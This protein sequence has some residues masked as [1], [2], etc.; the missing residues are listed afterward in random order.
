[1]LRLCLAIALVAAC[2]GATPSVDGPARETHALS[3][4]D[5][6]I[7]LPLP[8]SAKTP[9][10]MGVGDGMVDRAWFEALVIDRSDIAPKNGLSFQFSDFQVVAIRFE[11]CDPEQ[12]D[13]C[14]AGVAA[15]FRVVWQ[16]MFTDAG[17]HVL[18][19]DIAAHGFYPV[20]TGDI[21]TVIAELRT[22]AAIQGLEPTAP[23]AVSPAASG[24]NAEYLARLKAL[25]AK[26]A[27]S[28]NLVRLTVIGQEAD[29]GAFA[30]IFRGLD[31]DGT[32]FQQLLIPTI[33]SYQ[34]TT[35]V[36]AGDTIYT[37]SKAADFPS[38]FLLALNGVLFDTATPDEQERALESVVAVQ[39]PKLHDTVDTQCIG[40]HLANHLTLQRASKLSVDPTTVTG[41]FKSTF[42]TAASGIGTDPRIVR[43]FGWASSTPIVSQR[44]ANETALV[45]ANIAAR[46]PVT[47]L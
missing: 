45:L 14:P 9:V 38:G 29:S 20:P 26:Y 13:E 43:A 12:R 27:T 11:L 15:R 24:G 44:V 5:V 40:C 42:P 4:S 22:L 28:T 19:H 6:S 32:T 30:W 10:L 36:A 21:P 37:P 18:A 2:G 25:L 17:G 39:N 3:P 34:Q 23:L 8:A 47:S 31:W 7:L 16:P 33:R 46:Y 1:M 41:W 35:L